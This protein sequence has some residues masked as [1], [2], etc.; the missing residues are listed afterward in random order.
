[1]IPRHHLKPATINILPKYGKNYY[2]DLNGNGYSDRLIT[3]FKSRRPT[4]VINNH[5]DQVVNQFDM[6]GDW[7]EKGAQEMTGDYDKNG[8]GEIY[9][10]TVRGDSVFI[11]GWSLTS[12]A[13]WNSLTGL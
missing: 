7:M 4:V 5:L 2:Q 6:E 10:L 8:M 3:H 13:V 12:R 9:A 1:M 11:T